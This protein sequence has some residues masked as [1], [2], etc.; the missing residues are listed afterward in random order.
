VPIDH[1]GA[2][3]PARRA[4][5]RSAQM[6][7]Q[8]R[9]QILAAGLAIGVAAALPERIVAQSTPTSDWSFTDDRGRTVE[10]PGRPERIVAQTTAA[11]SLWDYGVRPIGIFGPSRTADGT[12]DFQA[13]NLDLDAV[14]SIGDYGMLDLEKLIAL[15]PDLYVDMAVSD[16]QLWYLTPEELPQ[17]EAI[18][19][20]IGIALGQVSMLDSVRRFEELAGHLGADLNAPEIVAAKADFSAAETDLKNAIAEKPGLTVLVL[21]P[22]PDTIYVATPDYMTDLYYFRDLGLDVITPD[23]DEYWELLSWEQL[24]K[25]P[26]DLILIDARDAALQPDQL[27][28]RDVWNTLPAVQAGQIGP[29]Y[30]GRPYSNASISPILREL[31]T[32]IRAARAD[33]V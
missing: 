2:T 12:P 21:S 19:P 23:A 7:R 22:T 11:A 10:L 13:G 17:V 6:R 26:A 18:V 4:A 14:E 16:E 33:L 3:A 1:D 31:T 8:T 24:G 25:Y 30:A 32:L 9:R 29:W 27:A 15:Q 5:S 20:T 28:E